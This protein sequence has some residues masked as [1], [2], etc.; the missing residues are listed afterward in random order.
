MSVDAVELH[1]RGLEPDD[2]GLWIT[3]YSDPETMRHIAAPLS[4]EQASRSF[5]AAEDAA[6]RGKGGHRVLIDGS[7]MAIAIGALVQTQQEPVALEVGIML[8]PAHRGRGQGGRGLA[9]LV[10]EAEARFGDC[11]ISVQYRPAHAATARMVA[12][13]GFVDRGECTSSGLVRA[14]LERSPRNALATAY[15]GKQQ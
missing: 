2:R 10:A 9:L 14:Y 8:V 1:W 7:G 5:D 11:L 13:L 3:L 15:Q 4:T 6:R 12:A